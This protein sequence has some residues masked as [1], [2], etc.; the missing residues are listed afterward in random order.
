[1]VNENS[2]NIDEV[3]Q[4]LCLAKKYSGSSMSKRAYIQKRESSIFAYEPHRSPDIRRFAEVKISARII[5][6]FIFLCSIHVAAF[7]EELQWKLTMA[8]GTCIDSLVLDTVDQNSLRVYR[9]KILLHIEIDS[10]SE[11]RRLGHSNL[12]LSTVVGG[13]VGIV[14]GELIYNIAEPSNSGEGWPGAW[15]QSWVRLLYDAGGLLAGGLIGR[16][17]DFI[18]TGDEIYNFAVLSRPSKINILRWIYTKQQST[19]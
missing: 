14:L 6:L 19:R 2:N 15:E 9:D 13:I 10:I 18:K 4:Y 3:E 7:S 12:T 17:T 5:L 8:D 11:I 1:M 16:Y